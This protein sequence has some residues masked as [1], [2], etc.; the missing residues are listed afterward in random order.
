MSKIGAMQDLLHGIDKIFRYADTRS[1]YEAPQYEELYEDDEDEVDEEYV[2]EAGYN[3]YVSDF[4]DLDSFCTFASDVVP[5]I[6]FFETAGDYKDSKKYLDEAKFAYARKANSYTE[7]LQGLLYLDEIPHLVGVDKAREQCKLKL[8]KFRTKD[9]QNQ[10]YAVPYGEE[11]TAYCFCSVLSAFADTRAMQEGKD[12]DEIDKFII[13]NCENQG[14]EY[15]NKY[16]LKI[17]EHE[18]KK[19]EL[20]KIKRALYRLSNIPISNLDELKSKTEYK[21]AFIEEQEQEIIRQEKQKKK[22]KIFSMIAAILAIAIIITTVKIVKNNGYAADNFSIAVVSKTNKD[23]NE[24]LATG[25]TGS[26]YFYNFKFEITNNSPNTMKKLTGNMDINNSNGKTLASTKIYLSGELVADE[27]GTWNVEV[28]V[29][30]GDKAIEI[31]NSDLS[32][33]EITFKIIEIEFEDGT[34]KRYTDTKNEVIHK[35]TGTN[36]PNDD[37]T[38]NDNGSSESNSLLDLVKNYAGNDA[39]LPDNY[40]SIDYHVPH[41]GC[42]S[43]KD[44]MYYDSYYI[45]FM[46]DEEHHATFFDNFVDKLVSNGYT[47]RYDEFEYEYVKNDTV[48]HFTNVMESFVYNPTTGEEEVEYYYLNYY[49]Y[50]LL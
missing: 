19:S 34:I 2:M 32:E 21:I 49:T 35:A 12:F 40:L 27:K 41:C 37:E 48:I 4:R 24:D 11:K 29:A 8:I 38:S 10:G 23:F 5:I 47:L 9:M 30:K 25:Y 50:S 36:K 3:K 39:I 46:V 31:W 1:T 33:L 14:F 43:Y 22:I 44:N 42:Y 16:G 26:G 28:N 6:K 20:I 13:E 18:S 45:L 17:I 7:A 15:I